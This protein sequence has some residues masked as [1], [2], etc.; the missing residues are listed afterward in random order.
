MYD[1]PLLRVTS[2]DKRLR[3]GALI[4][5]GYDAGYEFHQ[6]SGFSAAVPFPSRTTRWGASP[7]KTYERALINA[8]IQKRLTAIRVS[9]PF[10]ILEQ[11]KADYCTHDMSS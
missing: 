9:L 3:E 7:L 4:L 11:T 5:C 6:R 10:D 8:F 1:F 2:D